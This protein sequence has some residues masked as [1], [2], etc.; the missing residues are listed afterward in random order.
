MHKLS[1]DPAFKGV[2]ILMS[3]AELSDDPQSRDALLERFPE[4]LRSEVRGWMRKPYAIDV[5]VEEVERLLR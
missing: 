1:E 5:L 3:S 4:R 2:P